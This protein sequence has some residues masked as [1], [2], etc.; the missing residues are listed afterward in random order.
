MSV[1]TRLGFLLL[2]AALLAGCRMPTSTLSVGK[3]VAR[4]GAPAIASAAQAAAQPV[5]HGVATSPVP[6][7]PATDASPAIAPM[8]AGAPEV[9]PDRLVVTLKPGETV[10]A[11]LARPELAGFRAQGDFKLGSR[12]VLKLAIPSGLSAAEARARVAG[13]P[14]VQRVVSDVYARPADFSFSSPDP[15]YVEQWAHRADRGNTTNAW[16]LVP[17]SAQA[18]VIVAVLDTGLDTG[19]PEF[20]GRVI[21]AQNFTNGATPDTD[22]TDTV[23]HGT[24]VAGIVGAAGNNGQGVAGVAWGAQVMPVKVLGGQ[25]TGFDVLRGL[26]YAVHFAPVGGAQVRV[27]NLSLGSPQGGIDALYTEAIAEARAAGIVVIA[28]S[29]NDGR[30]VVNMPANTANVIAVGATANYL[31]W[32][33]LAPFSNYGDRLDLVA[34]GQDILSTFPRS[35]AAAGTN[36]GFESGTSMA[37]PY[38]AGVAALVTAK[39]DP[40][41][42]QA[43]AAFADQ[44]RARLLRAVDDFGLPGRDP[45]F[46]EG[47]LNAARAVTPANLADPP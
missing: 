26:L 18:K 41:N 3:P 20:A 37:A 12:M 35:G 38:V 36:Y 13:A 21:G 11:L 10:E 42:G 6:G 19:H 4:S 46:G 34:P 14:G 27:I 33:P 15:R 16:N 30:D 1:R 9:V 5:S 43:N 45:V 25:A 2:G 39:Y 31:N 7:A 40:N 29:G 23:G 8:A 24:H 17:P 22:V 47:R 28:A 44:V 32:E